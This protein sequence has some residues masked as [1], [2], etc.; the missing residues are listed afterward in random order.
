MLTSDESKVSVKCLGL[1]LDPVLIGRANT[2][3]STTA[4]PAPLCSSD[5]SKLE[6][7]STPNNCDMKA[8]FKACNLNSESEHNTACTSFRN[9][10]VGQA[11][12]KGGQN[13][14]PQPLFHLTTIFSTTMWIHLH[15][16]DD[17]LR[18]FIER[19]CGW[20]KQFLLV[21]PQPSVCY[22]KANKRLRKMGR[23]EIEDVTSSRLKMR[24]DIE[25]GIDD[26]VIRCGFRRISLSEMVDDQRADS[27]AKKDAI[28]SWN[29]SLYLYER[30][31]DK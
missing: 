29:R 31:V 1:D 24:L 25:K 23:P 5:E 28:T 16:G 21:E 4:S 18:E 27:K 26:T 13:N 3:F 7:V 19:A 12:I 15:G 11:E 2:K 30:V 22:R 17:G 10:K 20:T 6:H 14:E 8:M 9:E